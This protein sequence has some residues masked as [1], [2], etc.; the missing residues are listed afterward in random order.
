M[1][2]AVLGNK[3]MLGRYVYGYLPYKNVSGLN[4]D[5]LNIQKTSDLVN[6]VMDHDIIINCIGMIKQRQDVKTSD[7]IYVN[8]TFPHLLADLCYHHG[9]RMIHITTDC[10]FDGKRGRYIESDPHNPEDVYGK[11]KSLGEPETCTVIRTSIIGEEK[12]SKRSLIEWVKSNQDGKCNGYTNHYWNGATCLKLAQYI[13]EEI[14]RQDNF[15]K[16]VRHVF[17]PF[18]VSKHQLLNMINSIYNLNI[19]INPIE[20]PHYCDRTLRTIYD[21]HG[22]ISNGIERQI[23]EMR[24]W[25]NV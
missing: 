16:G 23:G 8:S 3:G 17:S 9:K 15:W 21:D 19:R 2:I 13:D 11:T 5:N 14:I 20:A 6:V 25:L 22:H 24:G 7:F 12:E 1:K 10:V 18:D 4:R